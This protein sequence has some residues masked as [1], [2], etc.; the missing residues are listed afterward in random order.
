MKRILAAVATALVLTT[1]Q[2]DARRINEI[3]LDGYCTIYHVVLSGGLLSAQDTPTCSGTY[4]GGLVGSVKGD[5][6]SVVIAL[7]DPGSPGVQR[8]LTLS[9]PFVTGGIFKLYETTDGTNFHLALDGTYSL[10]T[11]PERGPKSEVS[12]TARR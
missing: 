5:G 1:V 8:M 6:K 2:A 4:G 11:A 9:Y 7:Q 10:E 12:V 3:S